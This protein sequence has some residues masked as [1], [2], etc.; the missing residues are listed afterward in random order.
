MT[1]PILNFFDTGRLAPVIPE[2]QLHRAKVDYFLNLS[3]ASSPSVILGRGGP[4]LSHRQNFLGFIP[5]ITTSSRKA[6]HN[7]KFISGK[8]FLAVL[9]NSHSF[10]KQNNLMFLCDNKKN[11]LSAAKNFESKRLFDQTYR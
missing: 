1:E 2:Q 4:H 11:S 10:W 6:L 5:A 8:T 9:R 3:T 7:T